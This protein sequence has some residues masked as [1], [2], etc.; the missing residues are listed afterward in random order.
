MIGSSFLIDCHTTFHDCKKASNPAF[1]SI[2]GSVKRTGFTRFPDVEA[3]SHLLID[4]VLYS[5]LTS[6]QVRAVWFTA[7]R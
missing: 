3:L 5:R 1:P 6:V 2:I 4:A 7:I